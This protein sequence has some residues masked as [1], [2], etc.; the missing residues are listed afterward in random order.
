MTFTD[1]TVL[2]YDYNSQFFGDNV[3]RYRAIKE[4]SIKGILQNLTNGSGVSGIINGIAALE[5][6]ANDWT[7]IIINGINF[8]SGYFSDIKFDEG[9]DVRTK[10]YTVSVVIPETGAVNNLPTNSSYSGISYTGFQ[11]IDSLSES[12]TL[13]RDFEKDSYIHNI[14]VKVNS[15][16]ITG[17]ITFAK[18]IAKNLFQS[19]SFVGYLGNYYGISGKKSLYE[20]SYDKI[21]GQCAFNQSTDYFTNVVGNYSINKSYTYNREENGVVTVKEQGDIKALAEPYLDVLTN[22][23][24]TES[25][26]AYTNCLDAFNAYKENSTYTLNSIP[27]IKGTSMVRYEKIMNYEHTFSNDLAI[28]DGYFY[29]YTHDSSINQGGEIVTIEKGEIIGRSH[30]VDVRYNN[31]LT[32]WN[33][34]QAS[35]L[36]RSQTAYDNYKTFINLPSPSLFTLLN[37][38]EVHQKHIGSIQYSRGYSN[39]KTLVIDALIKQCKITVSEQFQLPISQNYNVFNFG[40]IEQVSKSYKVSSVGVDIELR[41]A[42]NTPMSSYLSYAKTKASTAV[43]SISPDFLTNASYSLSPI[44]NTF[45]LNVE[46]GKIYEAS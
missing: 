33:T 25:A 23:Y 30:R 18:S 46:W 34:I 29:N 2:S 10:G 27:I 16:N 41:G 44:S 17:S 14:D 26:N 12:L 9:I 42:R 38:T 32:A 31:A 21:N 13:S 39:D 7:S 11:W 5:G 22:A 28:N 20:E 35:I 6:A 24:Q 15:S 19:N 40:E 3:L 45:N 36:S 37:K 4:I 1:A 43:S 8:G